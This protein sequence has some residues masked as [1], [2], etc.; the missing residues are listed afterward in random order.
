MQGRGPL[1]FCKFHAVICYILNVR[2]ILCLVVRRDIENTEANENKA[3]KS[4]VRKRSRFSIA[5]L[6]ATPL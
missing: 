1:D 6:H 3:V 5:P 2:E 4:E